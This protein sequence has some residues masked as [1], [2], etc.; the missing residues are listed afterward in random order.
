MRSWHRQRALTS[1]STDRVRTNFDRRPNQ[2]RSR[3][4]LDVASYHSSFFVVGCIILS[5]LPS[6]CYQPGCHFLGQLEKISW[7][8]EDIVVRVRPLLGQPHRRCNRRGISR[9]KRLGRV[10]NDYL[11]S[12]LLGSCFYLEIRGP[13]TSPTVQAYSL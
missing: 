12:K 1:L 10:Q 2:W 6:I 8:E 11:A 9:A 5:F 3:V 13:A 7:V 4:T